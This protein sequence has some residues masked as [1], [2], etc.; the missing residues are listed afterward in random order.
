MNKTIKRI[1][2]GLVVTAVSCGGVYGGMVTYR[3]VN[4]SPVKVVPVR[5]LYEEAISDSYSFNQPT[6]SSG[7]VR[8]DRIQSV[9]LTDTLVIN[10]VKAVQGQKVKKGDVLFTYDTTLTEI[11]LERAELDLKRKKR[12]LENKEIKLERLKQLQPSTETEDTSAQ[13]EEVFDDDYYEPEPEVE[14]EVEPVEEEEEPVYI[15]EQTPKLLSGDGTYE[16]PYVYLWSDGQLGPDELLQFFAPGKKIVIPPTVTTPVQQTDSIA[17]PVITS[18]P[19]VPDSDNTLTESTNSGTDST[20]TESPGTESTWTDSTSTD[21]TWTESPGT[22][23]TW[24]ESTG[25]DST[26]TESPGT[27]STWTESPETDSTWSNTESTW[28]STDSGYISTDSTTSSYTSPS[29]SS[30]TYITDDYPS[31]SGGTDIYDPGDENINVD[32]PIISD[33]TSDDYTIISFIAPI[34]RL[35][36]GTELF[37]D[38]TIDNNEGVQNNSDVIAETDAPSDT[39]DVEEYVPDSSEGDINLEDLRTEVYVILEVHQDNAPNAPVLFQCGLHLFRNDKNVSMRLFNPADLTP[40]NMSGET[41]MTDETY[42]ED[43]FGEHEETEEFSDTTSSAEPVEGAQEDIEDIPEGIEDEFDNP[44]EDFGDDLEKDFEDE[45][46]E[47]ENVEDEMSYD[48]EQDGYGADYGYT[49]EG[50]VEESID[51]ANASEGEEGENK[52]EDGLIT[53]DDD[54]DWNAAYTAEEIQEN[55]ETCEK[56]ILQTRLDVKKAEIDL[57]LK[58]EEMQNTSVKAK[59]DGVVQTVREPE[60]AK[61]SGNAFMVVSG[62]GNYFVTA[63][64]G[65]LDLPYLEPG[66]PVSIQSYYTSE[67]LK[68]TVESVSNYPASGDSYYSMSGNTNVSAYPTQIRLEDG[69]EMR[70]EDYVEVS[71]TKNASKGLFIDRRFIRTEGASSYVYVVDNNG[72]LKKKNVVTGKM[73]EYTSYIQVRRGLTTEDKIAFPYGK[74]VYE[75]AETEEVTLSNIYGYDEY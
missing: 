59:V 5:S 63:P 9:F 27:D 47:D 73:I 72:K 21:S 40:S 33:T 37:E 43:G 28:S 49:D 67:T 48:G 32:P 44:E 50:P 61:S 60:E 8:S 51:D 54:F 31:D 41:D 57:K 36:E 65:E 35:S 71:F 22:D 6:F 30:G 52:E 66:T 17:E 25:T 42:T 34:P 70:D 46:V 3:T 19:S 7:S 18:I 45:N 62:G 64:F 74:D 69:A 53:T 39:L 55:I 26:W 11:Q 68:G 13:N 15:P 29:D 38:V 4:A 24:T 56:E 58:T 16:A 23:S 75:G 12:T 10:D 14:S 1:I 20:W 2:A